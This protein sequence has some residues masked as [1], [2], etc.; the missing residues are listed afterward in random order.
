MDYIYQVC[1]RSLIENDNNV[2]LINSLDRNKNRPIIKKFPHIPF[3][4]F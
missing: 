1:D 2:S 4:N 3:K